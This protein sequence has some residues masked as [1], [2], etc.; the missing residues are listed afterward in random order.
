MFK[1]R[2]AC[3]LPCLFFGNVEIEVAGSV[4]FTTPIKT[5]LLKFGIENDGFTPQKHFQNFL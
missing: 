3:K 4:L 2:D 1:F 5:G